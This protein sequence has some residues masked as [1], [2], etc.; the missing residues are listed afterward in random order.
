E[1]CVGFFLAIENFDLYA[2]SEEMCDLGQWNIVPNVCCVADEPWQTGSDDREHTA[3]PLITS[4]SRRV[5]KLY[6]F[7]TSSSDHTLCQRW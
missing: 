4:R 5:I 3:I 2:R 1:E 6:F 7:S